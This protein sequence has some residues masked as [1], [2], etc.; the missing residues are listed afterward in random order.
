MIRALLLP[1]ILFASLF[2]SHATMQS[3]L[4][5][6]TTS[7]IVRITGQATVVDPFR[8][9]VQAQYVCTGE[10]IAPKRVLTAAHCL[11]EQMRADGVLVKVIDFDK[12]YDLALVA[13]DTDKPSLTFRDY[14]AELYEPLIAIG[15]AQGYP[16][17]TAMNVHPVQV[18]L[19]PYP[20]LPVGILVQGDYIEGMSGGPVIDMDG[21]MVGMVQR[22]LDDSV[23]FGVGA[24]IIRAFLLGLL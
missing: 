5:G 4:V 8:G 22:H 10:V 17:V 7:S 2:H 21:D 18:N 14:E 16:V 12:Y 24:T 19:I 11:G 3:R 23:G 9:F 6:R 15:Y 1:F 13:V 20:G